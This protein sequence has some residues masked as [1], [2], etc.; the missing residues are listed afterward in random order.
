MILGNLES[1]EKTIKLL[2]LS[3]ILLNLLTLLI[4]HVLSSEARQAWPRHEIRL[5]GLYLAYCPFGLMIERPRM[6]AY[7]GKT[8]L[9]SEARQIQRSANFESM[10]C[11]LT[12]CPLAR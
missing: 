12:Y 8:N 10:G 9:S 5:D 11:T 6:A 2:K 3:T 7:H 4:S 1:L